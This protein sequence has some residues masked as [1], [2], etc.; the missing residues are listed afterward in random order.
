METKEKKTSYP[1][2]MSK[3][4]WTY[5]KNFES[6]EKN[7]WRYRSGQLEISC[8]HK[9]SVVK[10]MDKCTSHLICNR[11][12]RLS[13]FCIVS[14]LSNSDTVFAC[15]AASDKGLSA[16]LMRFDLISQHI[17]IIT[18][19][20]AFQAYS[21]PCLSVIPDLHGSGW[22]YCHEIWWEWVDCEPLYI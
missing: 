21:V 4:F 6:I 9:K 13:L 7:W 10:N 18:V 11:I 3:Q 1:I 17:D 5:S 2:S 19:W 16:L 8:F 22:T 12:S 15:F 20:A 14:F